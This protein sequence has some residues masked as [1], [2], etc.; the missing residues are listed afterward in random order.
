MICPHCNKEVRPTDANIQLMQRKYHLG[1]LIEH[2]K[3]R[4][5]QT[6]ASTQQTTQPQQR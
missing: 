6:V 3:N 4:K 1:C 2:L 5:E